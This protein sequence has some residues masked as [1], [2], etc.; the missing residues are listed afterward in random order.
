MGSGGRMAGSSG[1]IF[2]SDK[3]KCE[4]TKKIRNIKTENVE[5]IFNNNVDY[6]KKGNSRGGRGRSK[7]KN[8]PVN[9]KTKLLFAF[10][11]PF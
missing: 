9:S 8:K 5:K 2:P 1:D 7:P 3:I 6:R 11:L 10:A 4:R